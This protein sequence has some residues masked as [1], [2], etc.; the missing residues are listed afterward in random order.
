MTTAVQP[1]RVTPARVLRSEWHKLWTLRSTWI[2]LVATGALTVGMGVGISAAYDGTGEGGLDPVMF[3]LLGTQF[4]TVNLAVL[5]VLAT[6]GEYST[7]QI[8]ATLT[9]VPRR[10]PV[11]WSK[12]AVLA[13]VAFPLCLWTNLLT[14][15]LAQAFLSDT[16]Q[17]AAL[18]DPG[19]LRG[20]V[21]N[22]AA[23]TL[24][25]VMALGLGAV[26]RSVPVSLGVYIGLVMIVPELLRMLPYAVVDDAVR[27]FPAQAL[28]SATAAR[29][30]PE[31]AS[32]TA[33]L[34]ALALWAAVSLAAAAT[35]L[36]R[37]DV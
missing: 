37:R 20:L 18:G 6:A 30:G 24:L 14:F 22:A 7:G 21:G 8:R 23:L 13:A 16:D 32:P 1:Y 36:R 31:A 5:G 10:L 29:T 26:T 9:A 34:L 12:A 17:S 2:T 3:V 33:A 15:P 35:T 27:Y 4:A 19:V 25:A 28:E 11:L